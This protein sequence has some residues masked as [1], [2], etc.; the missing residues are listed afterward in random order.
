MLRP[1]QVDRPVGTPKHLAWLNSIAGELA[2]AT[3]GRLDQTLPWYT[4]LPPARRAA[5]GSVA[6]NGIT[7]FIQWYQEP[8]SQP[9]VAADVFDSAPRELL[10]SISLQE[11]LQVI[12]VVVQMVEERVVAEQPE[13]RDAVLTYSRDIAFS[14]ADVYAKAAEARGLW[15]ARLEALVVDSIISGES[16]QEISSRVAAL[17]WRSDGQVAVLLGSTPNQPDADALR[18]IARKSGADVLIGIQGRRQVAVIGLFEPADKPMVL[19]MGIAAQMESH[20]GTAPLVLGTVVG[21]VSDANRSAKSALSAYAVA[22]A[23]ET[24]PRPVIA[25]DLLP[26]RAL[27]GDS[28]AKSTLVENFYRPLAINSPELLVTLRAFLDSGRSLEA[29]SKKLFVHANTVRYRLR[30]IFDEVGLDPTH[31]R[32]GFVLQ[33]AILLGAINDAESGLKR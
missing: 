1:E 28:L 18:R 10:R 31:P 17:G 22:A 26:E 7:S 11:T 19:V 30:K 25:D 16:S 21:A 9:W 5:I 33:I 20:F 12:R 29:C 14:A 23:V 24:G 4:A 27:A 8:N 15:D 6:Q 13:L 3:I 2:T 32:S